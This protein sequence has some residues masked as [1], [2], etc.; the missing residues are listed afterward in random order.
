MRRISAQMIITNMGTPLKRGV[1]SLDEEGTIISIEDTGGNLQE[2]EAVEFYNGIIIPG[3][4]NSHCHL[5]LSHL[6]GSIPAASGLPS[7]IEQVRTHRASDDD[8]IILA[9]EKADA[10]MYARGINLCADICNTPLTFALKKESKI[11]Y[12]N[13]IEVFGIDPEKAEKRMSE[14][15]TTAMAARSSGLFFSIVP[16]SVYALSL[17]LLRLLRQDTLSNEITSIHFLETPFE[18]ELVENHSGPLM[19]SYLRSGL[20]RGR[21]ETAADHA[22]ALLN[23]ITSSGNLI[24]VHNLYADREIIVKI[25]ERRNLYWC[26]CP[27]SNY[28]IEGRLPSP[29]LLMDEGCEITL[30]TDSLASNYELDILGEMKTLQSA[31]PSLSTDI[32][33]RWSTFNG[34]RALGM[35]RSFGRIAKGMKPGLLLLQ[36]VDLP[37]MRLLPESSV[38][39]LA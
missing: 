26:L 31:F 32:L 33:V 35:E 39:R 1:I 16:H 12:I 23:E 6:K 34:A 5:E 22:T 37:S 2:K 17:P 13:L 10:A 3:F 29:D 21:I 24:L 25:K 8:E 9:A 36:D 4:V 27:N 18:K 14:A 7:F 19:E 38:R 11:R 28:F 15:V 30:G 20:V